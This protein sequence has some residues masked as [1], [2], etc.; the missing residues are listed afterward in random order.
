MLSEQKYGFLVKHSTELT[1]TRHVDNISKGMVE[2]KIPVT[3][4]IDLSK[5][6]DTLIHVNSLHEL[7]FYGVFWI[8]HKLLTSYLPGI[9]SETTRICTGDFAGFYSW[10]TTILY[11]H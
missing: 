3:I 2:Y 8:E 11:L 5:A 7:K 1:A 9:K 10:T 6:F 4:F